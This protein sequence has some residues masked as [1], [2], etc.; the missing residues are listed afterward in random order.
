MYSSVPARPYTRDLRFGPLVASCTTLRLPQLVHLGDS[1]LEF[2]VLA[3]LV[4]VSLILV[5]PPSVSM[6]F[7]FDVDISGN[8]RLFVIGLEAWLG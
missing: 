4:A 7:S 8:N 3:L 1:L 2:D 5:N 6:V